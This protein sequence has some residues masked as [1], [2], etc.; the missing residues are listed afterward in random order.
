MSID[1][2]TALFVTAL[3][4]EYQAVLAHLQQVEQI[5]HEAGTLYSV[6]R[7]HSQKE[8][9]KVVLVEI[10][11]GNSPAA[12]ETERAIRKFA[13]SYSFFV[14]VAGGMKD[15]RIGDV[16]AGSKVYGYELG[17]A[18]DHF[19]PRPDFGDPSYPLLQRARAV[20]QTDEWRRRIRG[21]SNEAEP[22]K[23]EALIGPIAAGEKVVASKESEVYQLLSENF[24]DAIAVEMEGFGFF[25]AVKA[26]PTVQAL[27]VRGISDLIE[28]KA[29]SDASGSQ[30]LAAQ[31]AAAFA[32]EVLAKTSP[33]KS[34]SKST[35]IVSNQKVQ[36]DEI[37]SQ[38][39]SL[40]ERLYPKGPTD[41]QIWSRAGGSLASLDLSG[42][43]RGMWFAALR[44]LKMGG[45]GGVTVESLI[46]AMIADYPSNSKLVNIKNK[47]VN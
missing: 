31:H 45:G 17:K 47:M 43:G 22:R 21:Q 32:F 15:V 28:G 10:G 19:A 44:K 39:A 1:D 37:W 36:E 2:P 5:E 13:P 16:V 18:R 8:A 35:S 41:N 25:Q 29:E 26:N 11:M 27:T 46:D 9:W 24:S 12:F 20:A 42:S 7:F 34:D 23:P 6:G 14:G 40:A 33:S 3:P 38:L 4:L 30:E